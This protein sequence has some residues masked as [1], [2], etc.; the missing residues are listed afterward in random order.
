LPLIL[1][2]E[3]FEYRT[4]SWAGDPMTNGAPTPDQHDGMG[5]I[6]T[7]GGGDALEVTI[8]RN[9]ERA[10]GVRSSRLRSDAS[11][12][13]NGILRPGHDDA[14]VPRQAVGERQPSL[15]GTIYNCA[16]GR[17]PEA[18]G[19]PAKRRSHDSRRKEGAARP[20]PKCAQAENISRSRSS[21][22]A[23]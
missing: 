12:G 7:Q 14:P 3:G 4:Y 20:T 8:V 16:G 17:R 23:A 5:A 15:G 10:R 19:F 1:L 13:K 21:T 18:P 9:H 2:P 6:V 11:S 22:W